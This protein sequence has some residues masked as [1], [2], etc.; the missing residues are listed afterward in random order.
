MD[1]ELDVEVW[2]LA[3]DEIRELLLEAGAEL[4]EEQAA[5]LAQFVS[6]AGGIDEA[7]AALSALAQQN[8]AA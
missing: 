3:S 1:E 2:D 4:S 8:R 5:Q 6:E 7:L